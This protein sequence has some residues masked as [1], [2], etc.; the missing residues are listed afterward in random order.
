MKLT[1]G[2]FK[3]TDPDFF[4]YE[5]ISQIL[6]NQ[7]DAEK[8]REYQKDN[9]IS[10]PRADFDAMRDELKETRKD[11]EKFH[12]WVEGS[13]AVTALTN[14]LIVERLKKRIDELKNTKIDVLSRD[15]VQVIF[16]NELQK[17]L[18]ERK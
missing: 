2:D 3:S 8:L 17:I 12:K 18:R 13:K 7:E 15:D 5:R 16:V 1:R 6:K 9:W 14:L 10:I 4:T 11:A